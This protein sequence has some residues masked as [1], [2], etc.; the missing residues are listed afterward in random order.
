[1]WK[2]RLVFK[3]YNCLDA[4]TKQAAMK[5]FVSGKTEDEVFKKINKKLVGTISGKITRAEQND[6]TAG[7]MWDKKGVVDISSEDGSHKFY[8]VE[9]VIAPEPKELK[10]AKGLVTS[11]YQE[12]LMDVWIKELR[13]KYAVTYNQAEISKMA[14]K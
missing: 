2:E 4:K 14:G 5:M 13:A 12:F 11:D 10:E 6:P 1:M 7:K 8:Y 3:T 9:G